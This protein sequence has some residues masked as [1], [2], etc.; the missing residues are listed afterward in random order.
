MAKTTRKPR[1]ARSKDSRDDLQSRI[2]EPFQM[3]E[4][5]ERR[6]RGASVK[7]PTLVLSGEW[8]K[9]VGFPIGSAAVLTTDRRGELAL[10]R[11]GLGFPRRL[12]VTAGRRPK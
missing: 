11:L 1:A 6:A 4:S 8:L 2:P 7:V 9:A 3:I 12:Y 10:N 5:T